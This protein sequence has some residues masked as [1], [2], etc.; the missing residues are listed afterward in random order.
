MLRRVVLRHTTLANVGTSCWLRIYLFVCQS[1][2]TRVAKVQ[3]EHRNYHGLVVYVAVLTNR[4]YRAIEADL[5]RTF[6]RK[7]GVI[8]QSH[9]PVLDALFDH[10]IYRFS[11]VIRVDL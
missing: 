10:D 8:T 11:P 9:L 2:E 4:F 1:R 3:F 7:F 6:R 5:E